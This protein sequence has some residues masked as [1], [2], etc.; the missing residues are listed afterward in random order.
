MKKIYLLT[1]ALSIVSFVGRS[2]T[3]PVPAVSTGQSNNYFRAGTGD[4]G[5]LST[6][7]TF[8]RLHNGFA[9]GSPFTSNGNGGYVEKATIAFDGRSGNITTLGNIVS[10]S[11]KLGLGVSNPMNTLDV[12]SGFADNSETSLF[13][14]QDHN[15]GANSGRYGIGL[16]FQ[17]ID[18]TTPGKLSHLNIWFGNELKRAMTFNYLGNVGVGCTNPDARLTVKGTV[19]AEE[20]KVE[21]LGSVCPDYVFEE[22]YDLISLKDLEQYLKKYKHL[23]EIKSA[24]EM[25]A[26][27]LYLKEMNLS[28]LRKVE[29]LTLYLIEQKKENELLKKELSN[30]D[31]EL[32]KRLL[33]IENILSAEKTK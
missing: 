9:I 16:S 22:N 25:E 32:N 6:Y 26:N 17:H 3:L 14:G 21:L 29:E 10:T 33:A 20:V 24:K 13:V 27:G 11:G 7:N 8:L 4:G 15:F 19:H 2:Q 31:V 28:L 18:G 30:V 23:P 5:T 12:L 1:I